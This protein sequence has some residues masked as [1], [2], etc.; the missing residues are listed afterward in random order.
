VSSFPDCRPRTE[1]R[2][3]G[4]HARSFTSQVG[5]H[6]PVLRAPVV[7]PP[8]RHRPGLHPSNARS[9]SPHRPHPST[10]AVPS[11]L[12][13]SRRNRNAHGARCRKQA[14][15]QDWRP[16]RVRV[17][18]SSSS[19][20]PRIQTRR[21]GTAT[22]WSTGCEGAL[23]RMRLPVDSNSLLRARRCRPRAV[24]EASRSARQRHVRGAHAR[25]R[26]GLQSPQARQVQDPGR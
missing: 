8:W 12:L 3:H 26:R 19:R 4:M 15:L 16:P 2:I 9:R 18:R 25:T 7:G 17:A 1:P 20:L 5:S 21:H 24:P 10:R 13:E 23:L 22:S 6:W 14:G 11:Q